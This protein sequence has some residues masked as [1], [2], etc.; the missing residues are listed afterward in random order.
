MIGTEKI[1]S[2]GWV[3]FWNNVTVIEQILRFK[4]S[5]DSLGAVKGKTISEKAKTIHKCS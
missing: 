5:Y 4:N 2:E 1:Q 3:F